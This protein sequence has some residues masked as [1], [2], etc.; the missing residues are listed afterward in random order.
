MYLNIYNPILDSSFI[1]ANYNLYLTIIQ[2]EYLTNSL[3][4]CEFF[5]PDIELTERSSHF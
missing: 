5:R 1:F 2:M 4:R 3:Y